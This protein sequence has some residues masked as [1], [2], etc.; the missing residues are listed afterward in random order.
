LALWFSK[1][2]KSQRFHIIL[3]NLSLLSFMFM[4]MFILFNI[5]ITICG[6]I[7]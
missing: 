7:F 6:E 1:F 2:R 4:F 5:I 3:Y